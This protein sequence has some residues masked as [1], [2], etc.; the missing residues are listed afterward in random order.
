MEGIEKGRNG[1]VSVKVAVALSI[2]LPSAGQFY[3]YQV[4]KCVK[5]ALLFY[6][7]L[8]FILNF[9]VY[10]VVAAVVTFIWEM[11]CW[12][13]SSLTPSFLSSLFSSL[14]SSLPS[15]PSF[16]PPPF[17]S[18][19]LRLLSTLSYLLY[20]DI[21]IGWMMVWM[22]G[23][24]SWM[25]YDAHSTASLLSST[26]MGWRGPS[27]KKQM[28]DVMINFTS[29]LLSYIPIT[30]VEFIAYAIHYSKLEYEKQIERGEEMTGKR[31][32]DVLVDVFK[33]SLSEFGKSYLTSLLLQ[34][35]LLFFLLLYVLA[36]L[37]ILLLWLFNLY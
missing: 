8:V 30:G 25:V 37:L 26:V 23:M 13:V 11:I 24:Y 9:V 6:S 32:V 31:G 29:L 35:L 12:A 5:Y 17:S 34:L 33:L 3:N 10:R 20:S 27:R 15:L 19:L 7:S 21:F 18:L 1:Q 28:A 22:V 4:S 36:Y 16:P 14:F 2:L